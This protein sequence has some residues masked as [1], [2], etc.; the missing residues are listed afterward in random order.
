MMKKSLMALALLLSTAN[1]L[2]YTYTFYNA[3]NKA[4]WIDPFW[5]RLS[6]A[7][8]Q[9]FEGTRGQ[10]VSYNP[11]QY[12]WS[13]INANRLKGP[14]QILPKKR[15]TFKFNE[16]WNA[17]LCV[18]RIF[19]GWDRDDRIKAELLVATSTQFNRIMA[20]ANSFTGDVSSAAK[21][22]GDAAG[23]FGGKGKAVQAVAKGSGEA[24]E[25][26]VSGLTKLIAITQCGNLDFMIATDENGI[27]RA[28]IQK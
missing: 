23:E 8:E 25:K 24:A 6:L 21:S 18:D 7:E 1:V 2:P 4:V 10:V 16:W 15:Y 12:D 13:G 3:T 14:I 17:G 22:V 20:A 9:M 19:L 27:L 5:S 11:N 26:L 28:I